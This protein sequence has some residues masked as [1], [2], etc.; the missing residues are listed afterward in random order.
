M[1]KSG[2]KQGS[3]C[4]NQVFGYRI[5]DAGVDFEFVDYPNAK[6]AFTNPAATELGKKF[7]IPI[8]YNEAADK[9]SWKKMKQFFKET[10]R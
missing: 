8:E 1:E 7:G 4:R 9:A 6:H 5:K 2:R 10:F 3:W